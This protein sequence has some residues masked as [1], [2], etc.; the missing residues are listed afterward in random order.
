MGRAGTKKKK[1]ARSS[2]KPGRAVTA[3]VLVCLCAALALAL[4]VIRPWQRRIR[5]P[6]DLTATSLLVFQTTL[7]VLGSVDILPLTGVTFPFV[8]NG[9]TAMIASW[10]LLAFLKATRRPNIRGMPTIRTTAK[11]PIPKS[12]TNLIGNPKLAPPRLSG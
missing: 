1:T 4:A 6:E 7:N 10:G 5:P 12:P 2:T 3:A 9:G 8:S 11:T